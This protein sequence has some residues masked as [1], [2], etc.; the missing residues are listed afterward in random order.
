MM[1]QNV[2]IRRATEEDARTLAEIGRT[3]F[4]AAFGRLY[5]PDDL[6]AFL[7]ASHRPDQYVAWAADNRFALWLAELD[8]RAAGYAL[9][10]PCAL[11]HPEVTPA[12]GELKRIYLSPQAQGGGTGG[13][14]LADALSW[15]QQPGRDLWLGVYSDNLGAQRLYGR[16]GFERV[17]DYLFPVG[18]VRDLEFILRRKG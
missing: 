8:G 13:R 16:H 11:P 3:T 6:A 15:L 17:G 9:A 12:C 4:I 7:E 10:G 1:S 14:L 18:R 5:P 2:T